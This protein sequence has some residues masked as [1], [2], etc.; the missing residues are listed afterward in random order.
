MRLDK[1]ND[2]NKWNFKYKKINWSLFIYQQSF[3]EVIMAIQNTKC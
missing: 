1:C 3:I 2:G